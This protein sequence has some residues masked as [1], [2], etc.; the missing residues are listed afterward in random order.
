MRTVLATVVVSFMV[1][2][3]ARAGHAN[4]A[5]DDPNG[6]KVIAAR[7]AVAS[8]C[9]C[10]PNDPPT[11]NHGQYVKC[12]AGIANTRAALDPNDPNSLPKTCKSA[13]KKGAAHST[14]GKPGFVTCCVATGKGVKCKIAKEL[15]CMAKSGTPPLD[16][17]NPSCVSNTEPLTADSCSAP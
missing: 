5:K 16:P 12:A 11:V 7:Q 1:L 4:C 2:G 9:T 8:G 10:D 6:V 3:A 15:K 13:V 17:N 14:C